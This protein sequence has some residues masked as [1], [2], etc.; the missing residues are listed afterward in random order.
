MND[1]KEG[2]VVTL[3]SDS[4]RMTIKTITGNSAIC[5]WR[6]KDNDSLIVKEF[7]FEMIHKAPPVIDWHL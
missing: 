1:F 5:E 7:G 3:K 6:S 4:C 2:D